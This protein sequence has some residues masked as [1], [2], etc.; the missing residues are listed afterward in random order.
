[1][2]CIENILNYKKNDDK[3]STS[4][5]PREEEFKL[6]AQAGF[7]VI[8]NIR[9][10]FEMLY[11]FDERKIVSSLG[12]DY[13]QIPITF[14]S[15]NKETLVNFFDVLELNKGKKIFVHCHRNIRVS[16][17][18]ILYRIIILGWQ[19][20]VALKEFSQ[21]IEVTPMWESYIDEHIRQFSV[22]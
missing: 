15:L 8:I 9:P 13:Y 19:R 7:E 3:L 18:V 6:I 4:G 21:F 1:M 14:D 11:V 22:Q 10:E 12:L 16:V 17:L 5:Q 2:N 20:E